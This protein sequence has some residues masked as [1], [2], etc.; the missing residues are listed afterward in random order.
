MTPTCPD[1]S[2]LF[3]DVY[4]ITHDE[5][6]ES[7]NDPW[8]MTMNGKNGIIYPFGHD[9]L[10]VDIDYHPAAARKVAAIPGVR[11]HQDGG[12]RGEM[13]FV[14]PVDLFEQVAAIVKPR[15]RR[16]LSP[17]QREANIARLAAYKFTAAKCNEEGGFRANE[18]QAG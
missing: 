12:L 3:G 4:R 1:L 7:R 9:L 17:E 13:T 2:E 10:A 11:L 5:A 14:F 15:K 16:K 6:A 8:G 18:L